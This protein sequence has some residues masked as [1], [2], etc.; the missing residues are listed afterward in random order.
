MD[1]FL[2]FLYEL[3]NQIISGF[4]AIIKGIFEGLK[5]IFNF[6]A[7]Y[8]LVTQYKGDFTGGEWVLVAITI[9]FMII[10]LSMGVF[11]I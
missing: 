4:F 8:N 3:V 5:L 10:F 2:R 7:F 9:L 6:T 11:S 1:T